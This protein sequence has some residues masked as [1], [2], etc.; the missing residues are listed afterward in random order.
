MIEI[1]V[2]IKFFLQDHERQ[3]SACL[4]DLFVEFEGVKTRLQMAGGP[5]AVPSPAASSQPRWTPSAAPS[6]A[7]AAPITAPTP[8]VTPVASS[9]TAPAAAL[10]AAVAAPSRPPASPAPH[11]V[12]PP[13]AAPSTAAAL[14]PAMAGLSVAA[15]PPTLVNPPGVPVG[16]GGILLT[17]EL[18][19]MVS[20]GFDPVRSDAA[21]RAT[22]G[23]VNAAIERLLAGG[24]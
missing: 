1:F 24:Q 6:T 14:T 16:P 11:G 8:A 2:L 13:S 19:K 17:P 23:N 3:L 12:A 21:L 18:D 20:M 22:Q 7:A 4:E 10:P 5:A 9:V 15:A